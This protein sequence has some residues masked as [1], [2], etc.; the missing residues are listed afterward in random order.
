[1]YSLQ[2]RNQ[3]HNVTLSPAVD[4]SRRP[5]LSPGL[6]HAAVK[7]GKTSQGKMA[8]E[9]GG[10][11]H[12]VRGGS[13]LTPSRVEQSA[14]RGRRGGL[15]GK[16]KPTAVASQRWSAGR[17]R[18]RC[19]RPSRCRRA[20]DHC[21]LRRRVRRR[22]VRWGRL[23]LLPRAAAPPTPVTPTATARGGTR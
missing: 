4:S 3:S 18:C 21:V 6:L 8:W 20:R 17:R 1:M 11:G 23:L 7:R 5:A 12:H 16:G 9:R 14:V 10:S 15:G 2:P 19:L 13:R 22:V